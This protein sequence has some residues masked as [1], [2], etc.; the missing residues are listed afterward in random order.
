MLD[1]LQEMEV[2]LETKREELVD[3][4]INKVLSLTGKDDLKVSDLSFEDLEQIVK[5]N[6]KIIF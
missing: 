1:E 2:D 5:K 3:Y 4:H 6:E